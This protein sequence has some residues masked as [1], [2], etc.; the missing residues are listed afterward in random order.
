[1]VTAHAH[2]WR[3]Q[4]IEA[5]FGHARRDFAAEAAKHGR[6]VNDDEPARLRD[7]GLDSV[8]VNRVQAAQIDH[9]ERKAII[10]CGLGGFE[11]HGNR[12]PPCHER[13]IRTLA[14]NVRLVML[15]RG[16]VLGVHFALDPV[17]AL[18]L[19]HDDGIVGF[20]RLTRQPIGV[21]S[22]RRGKDS[23]ASGVSEE[24]LGAL[25]VVLDRA[26]PSAVGDTDDDGHAD[27]A[28][29]AVVGFRELGRDLVVGGEHEAIKLDLADWPV[30]AIRETHGGAHDAGL[31]EGGVHDAQLAKLVEQTLRYAEHAAEPG[32]VLAHEHDLFV[33]AHRIADPQVDRAGDRELFDAHLPSPSSSNCSM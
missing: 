30:A 2:H 11:G 25:R 20:D 19:E 23:Q 7:G 31:T 27:A 1:M 21:I 10:L 8:K 13:E 6:L 14:H 4:A 9:F 17:A 12:R 18:G 32:D 24:Y 22:V 29:G 15:E 5:A 28:L 33:R 26:D 16:A 3:L